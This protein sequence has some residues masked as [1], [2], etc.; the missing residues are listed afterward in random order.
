ML[1]QKEKQW[2]SR[3]HLCQVIKPHVLELARHYYS[4]CQQIV[5]LK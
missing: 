2:V 3:S 4:H 1:P 5:V